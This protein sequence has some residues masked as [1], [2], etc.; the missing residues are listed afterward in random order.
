M[1]GAVVFD[2]QFFAGV[3]LLALLTVSPGADMALVSTIVLRDGRR[4]ALFA[5]LGIASGTLVHAT[6]SALGLSVIVA[7]SAEAFTVLKL[8][9]AA[10]LAY[11]GVRSLLD[12][13]SSER[14]GEDAGAVR[15]GR[16]SYRVGLL[17]NV[18]NPKVAVFYLTFL[19]QFITPGEPVLAKSLLYAVLHGVM[20]I[21]WLTAYAYGIL[22]LA[23][24]V[25]LPRFRVWLERITAAV[26]IG[27]GLRL[28]LERR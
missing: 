17:T 22:R 6:A 26:L 21:I 15:S 5:T 27:L 28:A 25:S 20:G 7:T 3:A 12:S 4:S 8:A 9:G 24:L 2:G 1:V 13:R 23:G 19:P 11:L 14:P 16:S 10:Y 18:L